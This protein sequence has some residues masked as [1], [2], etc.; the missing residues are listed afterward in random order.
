M[1]S[2]ETLALFQYK[3]LQGG[4]QQVYRGDVQVASLGV[5]AMVVLRRKVV[6]F[7]TCA[8]GEGPGI[9]TRAK[10]MFCCQSTGAHLQTVYFFVCLPLAAIAAVSAFTADECPGCFVGFPP[11]FKDFVAMLKSRWGVAS[12]WYEPGQCGPPATPLR[13]T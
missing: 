11:F 13:Q 2:L 8:Y 1:E 4:L 6:T 10:A 7:D 12:L 9:P 5:L 3:Y